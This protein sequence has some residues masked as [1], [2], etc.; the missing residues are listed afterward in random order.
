MSS[1][2]YSSN[3]ISNS[4]DTD[5][6][7]NNIDE[8]CRKIIKIMGILKEITRVIITKNLIIKIKLYQKK[9]IKI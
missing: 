9:M 2:N 5:S 4:S 6:A 3:Y 7:Y 1:S 8:H